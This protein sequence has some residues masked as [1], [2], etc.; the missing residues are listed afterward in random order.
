MNLTHSSKS[1]AV[2]APGDRLR[3][4]IEKP[5]AGG[6]M[7]ARHEGAVILVSGAIPGEIVDAQIEKVQRGTGWARTLRVIEPSSDRVAVEGDWACGGNV[8]A[9]VRYERQLELKRE[10]LRDAF[11]RIGRLPAP[12]EIPVAASPLDGY[13]MRARLHVVNGRIG[14]FREGTHALCDPAGTRQLLPSTLQAVEALGDA[15]SSGPVSAVAQ[16]ELSENCPA[17]ER[18][19]HL[20]LHDDTN[21]SRLG[22]LAPMPGV[23]GVSCGTGQGGRAMVL[24]GSPEVSDSLTVT[25]ASGK[26]AFTLTR[27]AHA[28]FQANRFLLETLVEA[29]VGH[30]RPGRALDLY[31]GVGLFSVALASRGDTRVTAIEGERTSAHDLKF[32]AARVGSAIEA[33]HQAVEVYLDSARPRD[34]DTVIVDPPRSGMTRDA[35]MRAIGLRAPRVV[36]VSCDVATLARDARA[37]VDAGYRLLTLRVFD[38]FPHT[39][40]VE[41]LAVFER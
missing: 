29:V 32:N 34:L 13:R 8:L 6:R 19:F 4:T 15:L 2:K 7:I 21:P 35:L 1:W 41:S 12:D 33:R 30:V 9:H 24:L 25:M 20:V 17:N 10:I 23:S 27:H 3:L 37:L 39:A 16:V 18:A 28:F 36:Y 11:A 38:L 5:A 22:T 14:F 40:H 26:H 31:A